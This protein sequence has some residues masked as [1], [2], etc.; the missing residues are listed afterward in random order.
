[1][2]CLDPGISVSML[3][4]C[5]ELFPRCTEIACNLGNTS[6]APLSGA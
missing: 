6:W 1:M 5:E 4:F 2:S 3:R